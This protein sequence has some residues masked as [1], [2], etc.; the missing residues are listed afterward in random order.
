MNFIYWIHIVLVI[1]I[2]GTP[3]FIMDEFWLWSH[4]YLCFAIMSHWLL[5]RGRC[6]LS[7]MEGHSVEEVPW[8]RKLLHLE[9]ID[10]PLF[11]T[12]GLIVVMFLSFLKLSYF[13]GC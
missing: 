12:K 4:I 6:A 9:W 11:E 5:N 13:H 10:D 7:E 8:F 3:F 2:L 1:F